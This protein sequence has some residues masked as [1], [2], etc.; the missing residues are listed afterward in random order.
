MIKRF[1]QILAPLIMLVA[2]LLSA[3]ANQ[4]PAPTAVPTTEAA[5]PTAAP[6]T[7]AVAPTAAPTEAAAAPTAAPAGTQELELPVW[8]KTP[9]LI[10]SRGADGKPTEK[11]WQ[12]TSH[13]TMSI[14]VAPPDR[15]VAATEVITYFNQSPYP[16]PSIVFRTYLNAHNPEADRNATFPP[17]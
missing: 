4:A 7:A 8:A 9:Y 1:P 2:L 13:H 10:G 11:Y 14:S 3:C 17:M 5:A 16:L 6:T 12:N 15:T